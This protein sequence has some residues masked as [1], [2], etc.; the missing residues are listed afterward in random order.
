MR[1]VIEPSF[2]NCTTTA[3]S[4]LRLMKVFRNPARPAATRSQ[5][6]PPEP[7][8][9]VRGPWLDAGLMK[10]EA[11]TPSGLL[12]LMMH[13]AECNPWCNAPGG[14]D[15]TLSARLTGSDGKVSLYRDEG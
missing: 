13:A 4:P 12:P 14:A 2:L 6:N 11:W 7:G 1:V 9:S 15:L 5:P 8:R 10:P 3:R